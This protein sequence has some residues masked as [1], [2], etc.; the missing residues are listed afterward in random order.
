MD[1]ELESRL[2]RLEQQVAELLEENQRLRA[3]PA[4]TGAPIGRRDVLMG[5]AAVVGTVGLSLAGSQPAHATSGTMQY[6]TG[7]YQNSG[8]TYT[9]LQ[10]TNSLYTLGVSNAATNPSDERFGNGIAA[11]SNHGSAGRLLTDT[12]SSRPWSFCRSARHGSR[13]VGDQRQPRG[14]SEQHRARGTRDAELDN[15]YVCRRSGRR[16]G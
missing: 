3:A 15:Q 1:R 7:T 12:T 2:A 6:G 9:G 4:E 5:A 16:Q 14:G 8:T 13:R 11:S 10:S